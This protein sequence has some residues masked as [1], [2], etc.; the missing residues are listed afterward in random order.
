MAG[1]HCACAEPPYRPPCSFCTDGPDDLLERWQSARD[2]NEFLLRRLAEHEAVAVTRAAYLA[3]C[4]RYGR[5]GNRI[6]M[7]E[8][9]F[10]DSER[11]T[12]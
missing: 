9:V 8:P 11:T 4:L 1:D 2:Q 5:V 7:L 10:M 12:K 6:Q 3:E